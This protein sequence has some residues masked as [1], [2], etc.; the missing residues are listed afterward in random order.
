[1][2]KRNSPSITVKEYIDARF[3]ST[4]HYA[5][6]LEKNVDQRFRDA[7]KASDRATAAADI[8]PEINAKFD[9]MESARNI[10][11]NRIGTLETTAANLQGRIWAVGVGFTIFATAISTIV[12]IV[13]HFF[14]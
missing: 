10:L 14:K 12:A 2:A 5:N 8:R 3:L 9:G 13:L 6:Q 7:E 4:E 1:M 11:A